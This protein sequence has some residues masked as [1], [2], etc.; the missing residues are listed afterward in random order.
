VSAR[1]RVTTGTVCLVAVSLGV[2]GVARAQVRATVDVGG[3][4]IRYNDS[5]RVT[6]TTVAPTI[7]LDNG[8][9][10]ALAFGSFSTLDGAWSSQGSLAAS[11]LSPAFG[12]GRLEAAASGGGTLHQDGTRT[13]RYLG[14]LRLHASAPSRGLWVGGGAGQG[15]N[16]LV[17]RRVIEGDVTGWLRHGDVTLLGTVRP[18]ATGD[19]IRY[20][21]ATATLRRDA[22]RLELA[23]SA[24]FRSG[25]GLI[26]ESRHAWASASAALWLAPQVALAADLGSYPADYTQG[27]RDGTY[28]SFSIRIAPGRRAWTRERAIPAT[29]ALAARTAGSRSNARVEVVALEAGRYAVRIYAPLARRVEVMGD[30]TD[31]GAAPLTPAANGWWSMVT[32]ITPGVRQ[33]TVRID[34]G[35]WTVPAGASME[36]DEYGVPVGVIMVR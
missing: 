30:F 23:A 16:G 1:I 21:D 28:M 29:D 33:L 3:A 10:T 32:R 8:P 35:Q 27:F 9:L 14:Q 17:W 24:G 7:R 25:R 12:V 13:G 22:S 34:G 15:W 6:A 20:T 19:S 31:W 18:V 36:E 4:S 2:T 11:L 26:E 5:V